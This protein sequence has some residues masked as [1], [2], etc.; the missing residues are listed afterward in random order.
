MNDDDLTSVVRSFRGREHGQVLEHTES[1][2]TQESEELF[3]KT[4]S[5]ESTVLTTRKKVLPL[6]SPD[7]TSQSC[8]T[9]SSLL[10]HIFE[11]LDRTPM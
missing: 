8:P 10:S 9:L 1:E 4:V 3:V 5:T 7:K 11:E 2:P 6:G